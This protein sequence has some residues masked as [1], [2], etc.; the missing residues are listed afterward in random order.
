MSE[1]RWFLG[2]LKGTLVPVH[3]TD[4][5]WDCGWYWSGG[6][7]GNR[8][9][10]AHF[11]GAFLETVD[12]RGHSLDSE[13]ATFVSSWMTV[14]EYVNPE[15]VK[16]VRNGASVWEDL[17]FFLDNAQYDERQ[18]WRIKDLF[19]QFYALKDAAEVFQYGGHC[20]SDGRT[21]GEVNKEMAASIN[22]H[23]ES[24]VI[25]EIR[26]ALDKA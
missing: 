3:L 12:V 10:H 8:N 20:S 5:K 23:I 15:K 21:A 24:V 4:F 26:K 1:K 11:V 2:N 19:K 18:W 22:K 16:V 6:Y 17:D 7:I 25:V 9:F 14:P 13:G